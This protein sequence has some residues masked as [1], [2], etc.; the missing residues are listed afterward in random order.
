MKKSPRYA[1]HRVN[2]EGIHRLNDAIS[3]EAPLEITISVK[4]RQDVQQMSLSITMRTPGHD[5]DL[6][7]GFLYTEGIISSLSD[8][9][10]VTE[11]DNKIEL[12]LDDK[13]DFDK[14]KLSRHFYTSSSCGICGKGSIEAIRPLVKNTGFKDFSVES[15]VLR[16]L[17]ATLGSKQGGYHE[18]GALHAAALFDVSGALIGMREDVGRHN[19]LDKLIG[20]HLDADLSMALLLLSGRVS[21]ELVHK[22]VVA[23]IPCIAA[24]GAPSTLAIDTAE[25]YDVTLVGFLKKEGYNCYHGIDRI[26]HEA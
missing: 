2:H 12:T 7:M 8:V 3:T 20:A 4:G 1:I 23:G 11:R 19:A 10:H 26:H 24:I 13:V 14:D 16:Q 5:T 21:F 18:T 22:A 15:Q 9:K 25:A 17:P 6:A